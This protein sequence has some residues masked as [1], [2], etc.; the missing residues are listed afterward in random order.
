MAVGLFLFVMVTGTLIKDVFP[1]LSNGTIDWRLFFEACALTIP[2][3][4]P[5]ALPMGVLAGVLIVL[6]RMSAQNEILA[7]KAAGMSLW[8]ITAPIFFIAIAAVALSSVINL[9]YAPRATEVAK[10]IASGAARANPAQHIAPGDFFRN[11]QWTIYAARREGDLLIRPWIWQMNDRG[12]AL[13]II[14]AESATITHDPDADVLRLV[15]VNAGMEELSRRNP[16]DF[17]N[18]TRYHFAGR[19]PVEVPVEGLFESKRKSK[20]RYYSL[21]GLLALRETGF[22]LSAKDKDDPDKRFANR[23]AVQMQIQS[24]LANAFGILSMT[25]LAIPLGI[26]TSR[27]ETLVNVAVALGL[28]LVF[29]V[30]TVSVSWIR[31]MSWRPDILV[32]L[33][34][35]LYQGI[36][37]W[38]LWRT[39]KQ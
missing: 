33:P 27:S 21:G 32:W 24:N 19:L 36:G 10:N 16:E 23:I 25:M 29:Y 39:A 12:Q 28:A 9:E 6:G 17:A 1:L 4:L 18:P 7:M 35:F 14:H 26:K 20:L 3:M 22:Q 2:S 31:D 37:G 11:K 5:Y 34:N 30:L 15:A 38:L 13:H 8:R